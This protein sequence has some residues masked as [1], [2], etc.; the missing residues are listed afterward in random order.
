MVWDCVTPEVSTSVPLVCI[1]SGDERGSSFR[2][3][4]M[5]W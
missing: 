1:R 2:F 3:I 5:C 4:G